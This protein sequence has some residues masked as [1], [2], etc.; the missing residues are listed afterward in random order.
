VGAPDLGGKLAVVVVEQDQL[1]RHL[2]AA[3]ATVVLVGD[4]ADRA[5]RTLAAIEAAGSGRGAYFATG[6]GQPPP[7]RIEALVEFVAEQFRSP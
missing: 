6:P 2:A 1:A 5:G 4:D 3:G 7:D